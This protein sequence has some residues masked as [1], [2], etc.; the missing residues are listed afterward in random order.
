MH[1]NSNKTIAG[2]DTDAYIFGTTRRA[3][4]PNDPDSI[5]RCFVICGSYLRKND[6]VML[7]SLSKVYSIFATNN[8]AMNIA[9]Q[10]QPVIN[11][12]LRSSFEPAKLTING[13]PTTPVWYAKS[14]TIRIRITE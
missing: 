13:K 11:C 10:G 8:E 1:R 2:W 4:T 12:A 5:D 14:Q 6:K 9:I 3:G 7:D